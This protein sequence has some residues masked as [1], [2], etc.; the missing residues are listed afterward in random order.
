MIEES[1][2]TAIKAKKSPYALMV[3]RRREMVIRK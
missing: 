1:I 3:I 2:V